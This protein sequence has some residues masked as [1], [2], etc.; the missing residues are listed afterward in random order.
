MSLIRRLSPHRRR[1]G[2]MTLVEMIIVAT[3]LL[4]L[5]SAT[6]PVA[7]YS[8][9]RS[10]EAELRLALR[11]M[12]TAVDEFKRYSDASLIPIEL[13]TDGYPKDLE[14]LLEPVDL[15]GQVDRQVRFLRRIPI[16]P[17]VGNNEDWILLSYQDE[18]DASS[19]GGE[20]IFDV[21]SSSE[22]VG[23]NGLPYKEW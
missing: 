11:T 19:W 10:K 9:R 7:K 13:G 5:A 2:G 16:D 21:R 4:I 12:R 3:L 6:I 17:M 23:L 22:G 20:N 8:L 18:P 15:V 14:T 1:Q